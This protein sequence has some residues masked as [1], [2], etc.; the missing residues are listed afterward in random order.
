MPSRAPT[1]PF[2]FPLL[3]KGFDD[4]DKAATRVLLHG[5]DSFCAVEVDRCWRARSC[6]VSIEAGG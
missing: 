2:F 5:P 6:E 4:D 3:D 1:T